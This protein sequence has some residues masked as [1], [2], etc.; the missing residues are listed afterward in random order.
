MFLN[1][2][3][4]TN[5]SSAAV[6]VALIGLLLIGYILTI[7]PAD[8]A[9]LLQGS[10]GGY[11]GSG[12]GGYG[13]G[14]GGSG[15][16]L[17]MTETPGTLKIQPSPVVEHSL[18]S[19]TVFTSVNTLVIK[20][21]SS[22][23]IKNSLF[24]RNG[25]IF[26]FDVDGIAAERFLL[27]FNV[28][29]AKGNLIIVLN[30]KEIFNEYVTEKSPQPIVLPQDYLKDGEN[31]LVFLA[32]D[33]GYKFWTSNRYQLR[34]IL[35]SADAIDFRAATSEQLFN[36][37]QQEFSQLEYA[38]VTFI[39]ECDPRAAGRLII[40]VNGKLIYS[41][42][43]DCGVLNK[44]DVG[45]DLLVSGSNKVLFVSDQGSYLL[46]RIRIVSYLQEQD[47][48]VYYF[49]LP[50]ELY[51]SLDVGDGQLLL[52]MRFAD[53]RPEKR[54]EVTINGFVQA[55]QASEYVYQ[56]A[57]DPNILLPGP[58]TIQVLPHVDVLNVAEL[59]I[60]MI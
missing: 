4:Q 48:P 31:E 30:G 45:Q 38:Q 33:V 11:G 56:A 3:A 43:P 28:D 29:D 25:G 17:I 10:G 36:L 15:P 46:D 35:V 2:S 1:K 49:N 18:P 7:S 23:R 5:A 44:I 19:T 12:G 16:L 53:Y 20:E 21:L 34:N 39:P 27:S 13:G 51:E 22:L 52:T 9:A 57:I 42:Y 47:Y 60:E 59:R 24:T 50:L 58:N 8:R 6:L 54:G 41:G 37:P 32:G 40:D 55:F 14:Y 26:T